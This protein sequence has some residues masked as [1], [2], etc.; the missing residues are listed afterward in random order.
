MR[1]GGRVRQKTL[2]H[3]GP[4]YR[5]ASGVPADARRKAERR[6]P[7]ADWNRINAEIR[8]V[9]LTFVELAEAGRARYA[10]TLRVRRRDRVR[11]QG[12]LPRAEGELSAL[13]RLATT[14]F[15]EMFERVGDRAYRIRMR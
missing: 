15:A 4:L 12:G 3:L 6:V 2:C 14:G 8:R 10:A 1:E 13:T 9:P 7:T 5:L 11:S